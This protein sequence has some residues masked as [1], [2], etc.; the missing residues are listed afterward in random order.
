MA[1][2]MSSTGTMGRI[3]PKISLILVDN[4]Q[5]SEKKSKSRVC[6]DVII[7]LEE[8]VVFLDVS[9]D[10]RGDASFLLVIIPTQYD[11]RRGFGHHVSE[12]LKVTIGNDA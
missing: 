3:G 4:A 6:V 9:V 7:P 12:T 5:V 8:R 2:R 1:C 10:G 11:L